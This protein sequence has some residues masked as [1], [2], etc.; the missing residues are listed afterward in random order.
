[1]SNQSKYLGLLVVGTVLALGSLAFVNNSSG[2]NDQNIQAQE[3]QTI[4]S[5]STKDK[6]KETPAERDGWLKI[7]HPKFG[8]IVQLPHSWQYKITDYGLVFGTK[9]ESYNYSEDKESYGYIDVR[10][11]VYDYG[12]GAPGP[13]ISE[14]KV[15]I[16]G[17]TAQATIY[18]GSG[19]EE[20]GVYPKTSLQIISFKS[21]E[22]Y[23]YLTFTAA[24][25]NQPAWDGLATVLDSWRLR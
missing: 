10:S 23:Y 11:A 21:A 19:D 12:G 3:K 5:E 20:I 18:E 13:K 8:F 4:T 15:E 25:S 7:T 1:M 6:Q 22:Q 2:R 17:V 14:K 16:D 9:L 24:T